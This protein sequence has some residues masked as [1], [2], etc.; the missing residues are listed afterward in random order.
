MKAVRICIFFLLAAAAFGAVAARALEVPYDYVIRGIDDPDLLETLDQQALLNILQDQPP[1]TLT[2]L[3]RRVAQ[4]A[5]LFQDQLRAQGHFG[6][7]IR[8]EIDD[9]VSPAQ[10][11]IEVEPGPLYILEDY[12]ISWTGPES[13]ELRQSYHEARA[14]HVI[15]YP[16]G[17]VVSPDDLATAERHALEFIMRRGHPFPVVTE[18]ELVINH[19]DRT[20]AMTLHIDVGPYAVFGPARVSGNRRVNDD[21]ILRRVAW[22]EGEP[23]DIRRIARTRQD[24]TRTGVIA[25]AVLNYSERES[26][27]IDPETEMMVMPVDI[28]VQEGRHRSVSIGAFYS[29][30]LGPSAELSWEHRN[31]FG[32][33]ERLRIRAELG[34]QVYGLHSDIMVP[35]VLDNV[36]L[37]FRAGAGYQFESL[38]AFDR[39]VLGTSGSLSW[40]ITRRLTLTGGLGLEYTEIDEPGQPTQSYTLFS[41]PLEA[42]YDSTDDLLDPTRGFRLNLSVTPTQSLNRP[43]YFLTTDFTGSHYLRVME[44]LVWANRVR[45]ANVTGQSIEDLPADR[46]LF[47]G[48]GGSVRGYGY[49]MLGPLDENGTP[50]G[51]RFL[52]EVGTEARFRMTERIGGVVFVEGGRLTEDATVT[53]GDDHFRWAAGIGGRYQTP[54]GPIRVDIAMPVNPR[55]EDD[56]FQLYVSLGQAF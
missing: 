48:G 8:F 14:G 24:L 37:T 45:I 53:G 15:A 20:A 18:R 7:A 29:T 16:T 40:A 36:D 54:I 39:S 43:L 28:V 30:T 31:L 42:R 22:Q 44:R 11:T 17:G 33:A 38:E 3:R 26:A 35:D 4:D 27:Y 1:A 10:I 46:R 6:S 2:G 56:R 55:P 12:E 19:N 51:G 21:F 23:F 9:S 41:V 52:T 13:E 50:R 5:E 49:Q 25:S 34:T 47:A 32:E